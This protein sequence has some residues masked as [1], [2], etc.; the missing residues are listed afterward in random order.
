ML[1]FLSQSEDRE[2]QNAQENECCYNATK[3]MLDMFAFGGKFGLFNV[4]SLDFS[5]DI[6]RIKGFNTDNFMHKIAFSMSRDES[7]AWGYRMAACQLEEGL[8][9]LY[10]DGVNQ[11]T[12]RPYKL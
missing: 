6:K 7:A 3:D 11:K 10:T 8:T 5:N 1:E 12:F 4:V 2:A 9:A